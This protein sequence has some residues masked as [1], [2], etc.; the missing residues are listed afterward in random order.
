MFYICVDN[1]SI[2]GIL[3]VQE[4]KAHIFTGYVLN[5]FAYSQNTLADRS[6]NILYTFIL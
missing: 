4:T 5:L 3:K 1:K 2:K 6:Y